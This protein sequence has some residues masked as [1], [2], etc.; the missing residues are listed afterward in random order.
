MTVRPFTFIPAVFL[1]PLFF[2]MHTVYAQVCIDRFASLTFNTN[3]Y[4]AFSKCAVT[5]SG[6][7]LSAGKLFDYNHAGHIAKYSERGTSIWSYTYRINYFD[8]VK[9]L[10]FGGINTADMVSTSNGDFIIAG[11]AEQVLPPFGQDAPVKKWG[12]L[13]RI[14]R[15]GKV[16]WNK[17]LRGDY[18]HLQFTNICATSDG[19]FIAYLAADNGYKRSAGDHTYNR[20]FRIGPDGTVK[21]MSYLFTYLFDAGGMGVDNKRAIVQASNGNIIIGDVAHKTVALN[22]EI[23]EGNFHFFELDYTTGHINWEAS[24]EFGAPYNTYVPDVLDVKEL[25]NGNLSFI[26]NMYVNGLTEKGANII[27]DNRGQILQVIT[28]S[29]ADGTAC[30]IKEV[31]KDPYTGQRVVLIN[32]NGKTSLAGCND[33]GQIAWQQGYDNSDGELP[34]NCFSAGKSGYHL[35][36][37]NNNAKKYG[38]LITDRNGFIEC[39]NESSNIV[40]QQT[41]L[42]I[43]HDSLRTDLSYQYDRYYDYA[44]PLIRS[45]AYPL[46]KN[47][48]CRQTAICCSDIIDSTNISTVHICKGSSYMLPDSTII[49]DSGLY[50]VTYKTFAGCDSVT[51]YHIIPD[52]NTDELSLGKDTCLGR[53]NSIRIAATPGYNTYYWMDRALPDTNVTYIVTHPGVYSVGVTNTCGTKKITIEVFDSCEYSIYIPTAFTPNSDGRNDVFRIPLTNKNKLIRLAVYNRTGNLIFQTNNRLHGWDGTYKGETLDA[54]AFIY[55]IEM[56]GITG[57]RLTKKGYVVLLR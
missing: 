23:K 7:I 15:F 35:F 57:K 17:T 9:E 38:L 47:I 13:A 46:E 1:L 24:H 18:G 32:S 54:G 25:S 4:E 34:V 51:Y 36:S 28:Y 6:E 44:Y 29:P 14:D 5:G 56:E 26:T 20:V 49:Q 42:D 30:K 45:A 2:T 48:V 10:F 37:S 53:Q 40:V 12:L 39:A 21:W 22:G 19:D 31:I 43:T 41:T 33:G 55:Y 16:V 11:S 3:T 50:Y 27:T 8:F 52:K